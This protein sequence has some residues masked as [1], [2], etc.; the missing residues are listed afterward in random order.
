MLSINECAFAERNMFKAIAHAKIRNL[1]ADDEAQRDWRQQYRQTEDFLTAAIFSRLAYLTPTSVFNVIEHATGGSLTPSDPSE[2]AALF[3]QRVDFW[4]NWSFSKHTM[5]GHHRQPDVFLRYR[6]QSSR[7]ETRII[8]EAKREDQRHNAKQLAEEW[9]AFLDQTEE[10]DLA[11]NY[12]FAIGGAPDSP[13]HLQLAVADHLRIW[14]EESSVSVVYCSWAALKRAIV[15][16]RQLL[17]AQSSQNIMDDLVEIFDFHGF[18]T[19]RYLCEMLEYGT[20][21]R[22]DYA[23]ALSLLS[24]WQFTAPISQSP[25]WFRSFV[26]ETNTLEPLASQ[27]ALAALHQWKTQ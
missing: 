22:A 21:A 9:I 15:Q 2:R 12:I 23:R 11:D 19:V 7:R 6:H 24:A 13:E 20:L 4:P 1:F 25:R 26:V 27:S 10:T 5:H 14:S 3:L 16:E 17:G 18:R 8:V